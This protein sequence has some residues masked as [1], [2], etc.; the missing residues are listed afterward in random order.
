MNAAA[1]ITV[2]VALIFAIAALTTGLWYCFDDHLAAAFNAPGLGYLP[3]WVPFLGRIFISG[4]TSS[5][6]D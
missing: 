6:K 4:N 3:W 5:S 1:T 2:C